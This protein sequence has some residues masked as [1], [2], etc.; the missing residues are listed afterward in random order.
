MNK[1]FS[2]PANLPSTKEADYIISIKKGYDKICK[3]LYS[4]GCVCTLDQFKRIYKNNN[5]IS[6][7]YLDKKTRNI[8]VEMEKLKLIGTDN[9][10]TY[11]FLYLKKFAFIFITGDYTKYKRNNMANILKD[12]NFK[13]S[14][15]RAEY[16]I[17]H[18]EI[19]SY[20][21]LTNNL[22]H[23]T[24]LIYNAKRND[25]YLDYDLKLI[26]KIIKDKGIN[27]CYDE[28]DKL[29]E[30]NLI[31]ILWIDIN[32]IYK[33]LRKQ[34]QTIAA[35]PLHLKLYKKDSILTL[36]YAPTIIIFDVFNISYYSKKINN[37]FY[38][39]FNIVSNYTRD[40]RKN[41][42]ENSSL[43]WEG[44]NH[45]GYNLKII[46]YNNL[47]L[48]EKKRYIDKLINENPNGILLTNCSI[49]YIDISKYFRHS[50]RKDKVFEN[51]DETF[52]K[53][54]SDKI[55]LLENKL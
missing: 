38:K 4:L 20:D 55:N 47:E 42:L 12:K 11:K 32:N 25:K 10:N 3:L 36:H 19:I 41:F 23:I 15:M 30:N 49:E 39:Y 24:T 29:P 1:K 34:N 40:M 2:I 50:S 21:N 52:N 9:I 33:N 7:T 22:L 53:L 28:V 16:Y 31:R 44:Y 13:T 17:K 45:F 6:D 18:N 26:N 14:L 46:G 37:L 35:S 8:I 27:N 51:I 43:G 54:L 5:N 48:Y